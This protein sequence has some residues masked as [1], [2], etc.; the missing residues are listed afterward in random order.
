MTAAKWADC[1]CLRKL[2]ATVQ[3]LDQLDLVSL[4]ACQLLHALIARLK[5]IVKVVNDCG[6][7]AGLQ[8]LQHGVTAC[9][10]KEQAPTSLCLLVG[11][12]ISIHVCGSQCPAHD[13]L[14]STAQK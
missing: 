12:V 5:S 8:Q 9:I 13:A 3:Y 4:I 14:C 11:V 6:T 10:L 2:V 1:R 7:V